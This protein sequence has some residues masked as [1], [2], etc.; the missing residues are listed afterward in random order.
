MAR[1]FYPICCGAALLLIGCNKDGDFG[2]GGD[3]PVQTPAPVPAKSSGEDKASKSGRELAGGANP[4]AGKTPQAEPDK[5]KPR[6]E[7]KK[8]DAAD[9]KAALEKAIKSATPLQAPPL[10]KGKGTNINE[11]TPSIRKLASDEF[12]FK[13]A[14]RQV[15]RGTFSRRNIESSPLIKLTDCRN[16]LVFSGTYDFDKKQATWMLHLWHIH[17]GEK[18]IGNSSYPEVTDTCALAASFNLEEAVA[19]KWRDA[20]DRGSLSP[21]VWFRPVAVRDASWKVHPRWTDGTQA[22]NIVLDV[23][24]IHFEY[25]LD[26]KQDKLDVPPKQPAREKDAFDR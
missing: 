13:D 18:M 25:D 8:P 11:F 15:S 19:R 5:P 12:A 4:V 23:E 17:W 14:Q 2:K 20:F 1:W 10:V 22:H 9:Q 24:V 6:D 7:P 21:T 3:P 26:A 16:A